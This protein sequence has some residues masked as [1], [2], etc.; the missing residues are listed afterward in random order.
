MLQEEEQQI[1]RS[2]LHDSDSVYGWISILLHWV[3][4]IVII[5]LWFLGKS[6]MNV[7]PEDTD[8]QRQLHVSIAA[9]AWIVILLRIIWRFRSGHPHVKGQ[10]MVTHRVAKVVHYTMLITVVLML[11]SGPIMVW[12]GGNP[13]TV[14]EWL[15]I[16]GPFSNSEETRSFAW[17][18]HS[19]SALLLS[20][21]VMLHIGG[22]LKHLM[23]HSDDTVARMIW[24][25]KHSS[26]A[27]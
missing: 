22:A 5:I 8:A 18:I 27:K 24:P 23:F 14:F 11:V 19:N 1:E 20:G 4:A 15:S 16:P 10:T 21:L 9:S 7:L 13:I 2:N 26:G 12:S 6:I 25:G 17:F 3:T